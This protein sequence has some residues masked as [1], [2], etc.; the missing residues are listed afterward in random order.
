MQTTATIDCPIPGLESVKVTFN[1]LAS[2]ADFD[3]FIRS[4]SRDGADKVIVKIEG[5]PSGEPFDAG[6]PILFRLWLANDGY[7]EAVKAFL[8]PLP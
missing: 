2:E 5:W 4:L 8:R 7:V 6:T 3:R 1:L